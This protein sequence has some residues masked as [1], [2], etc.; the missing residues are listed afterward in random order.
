M[1]WNSLSEFIGMG[2]YGYFV[3][4]AYG[5]AVLLVVAE[6]VSLAF[7]RKAAW[8]AVRKEAAKI[9]ARARAGRQSAAAA[10]VASRLPQQDL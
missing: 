9:A 8:A 4:C 2:G 10:P 5:M 1:Q 7:G 3:W 6:T